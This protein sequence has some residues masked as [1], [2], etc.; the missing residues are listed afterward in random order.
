M[1]F[2][3]T[4]PHAHLPGGGTEPRVTEMPGSGKAGAGCPPSTAGLSF[5]GPVLRAAQLL[6]RPCHILEACRLCSTLALS[7]EAKKAAGTLTTSS[8]D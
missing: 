3:L 4:R 6:P 5:R 7:S 8:G 2:I 1:P